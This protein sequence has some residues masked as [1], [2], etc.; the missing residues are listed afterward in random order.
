MLIPDPDLNFFPSR[1]PNPGVKKASD[2]RSRIRNNE[3]CDERIIRQYSEIRAKTITSTH[4][5]LFILNTV[6]SMRCFV[7]PSLCSQ[8]TCRLMTH[9]PFLSH[10]IK[11]LP[12][13]PQNQ[14]YKTLTVFQHTGSRYRTVVPTYNILNLI[15]VPY[16]TVLYVILLLFRMNLNDWIRFRV[17]VPYPIID[18]GMTNV[19]N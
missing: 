11:H 6:L 14:G 2:L 10:S 13:T 7:W 18:T 12:L 5:L 19:E 16:G 17:P 15:T 4:C 9:V 3:I 1:I 8:N